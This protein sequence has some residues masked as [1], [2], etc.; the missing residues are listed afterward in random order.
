M[1]QLRLQGLPVDR[2]ALGAENGWPPPAENADEL[3][4]QAAG[5]RVLTVNRELAARVAQLSDDELGEPIAVGRA[6]RYQVIQGIMAHNSYHTCEI[7][8][9][10]YIAANKVLLRLR[11]V[12]TTPAP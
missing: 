11:Q 3:A 6:S 12:E 8:S 4:W 2:K 1:T 10:L 9:I 7:I 5:E